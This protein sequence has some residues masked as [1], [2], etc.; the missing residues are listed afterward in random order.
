MFPVAP[1]QGP[2]AALGLSIAGLG[3][4]RG[5]G[6]AEGHGGAETKLPA[7]PES[8][9][10][11]WTRGGPLGRWGQTPPPPKAQARTR[12]TPQPESGPASPSYP[13]PGETTRNPKQVSESRTL[14]NGPGPLG[15]AEP[16][17]DSDP[18]A[19]APPSGKAPLGG[20]QAAGAGAPPLR[21]KLHPLTSPPT[22]ATEPT[23]LVWEITRTFPRQESCPVAVGWRECEGRT[24]GEALDIMGTR[25]CSLAQEAAGES[26]PRRW[27]APV[28]PSVLPAVARDRGR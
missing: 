22:P 5:H 12:P 7:L 1:G 2:E 19:Q 6:H 28:T 25:G 27:E 3:R 14:T 16:G 24:K 15:K 8:P 4:G 26:Y 20:D 21:H 13:P 18:W 10:E 17:E 23:L 9:K 11:A